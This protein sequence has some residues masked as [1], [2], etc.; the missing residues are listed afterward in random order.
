MQY[1]LTKDQE[2]L[3]SKYMEEMTFRTIGEC[4]DAKGTPCVIEHDIHEIRITKDGIYIG[5]L[6]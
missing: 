5:V 4:E 1:K 2:P 6:N 3:L